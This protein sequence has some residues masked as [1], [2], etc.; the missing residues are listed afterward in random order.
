LVR[1]QGREQLF[2]VLNVVQDDGVGDRGAVVGEGDERAG[3]VAWIGIAPDK[4][5]G[6]E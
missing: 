2:L 6:L 3:S 5:A 1:R 4:A